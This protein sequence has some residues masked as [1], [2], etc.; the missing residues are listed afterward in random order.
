MRTAILILT[1][2][3]AD[4]PV[5][6]HFDSPVDAKAAFKQVI[7]AD[8]TVGAELWTSDQGRVRRRRCKPEINKAADK[9]AKKGK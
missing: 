6:R 7:A 9:A 4:T 2:G 5:L 1:G 8:P 3:E